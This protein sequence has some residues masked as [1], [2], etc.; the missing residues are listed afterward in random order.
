VRRILLTG[1]SG[2][3][4]SS[5]VAALDRLGYRAVDT[6][7]GWCTTA[8]DGEWIWNEPLVDELLSEDETDVL[9]VAGCASN[10]GRFRHRFD[11]VILLYAPLPVMLER[12]QARTTNPFGST[13]QDIAQ[14][15][16]DHRLVEPLLRASA[17]TELATDRPFAAVVDDVVR[18]STTV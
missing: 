1:L 10:Q 11:L 13:A 6:D 16:D 8:P 5:L 2:T 9:F 4:K 3:G 15:T 14:I 17:D 18:L 12:V 7:D